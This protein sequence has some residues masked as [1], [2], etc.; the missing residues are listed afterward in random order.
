VIDSADGPAAAAAQLVENYDDTLFTPGLYLECSVRGCNGRAGD[1]GDGSPPA[2]S[3]T[4]PRWGSGANPP[5]AIGTM[6]YYAHKNWFLCI[7]CLYFIAKTCTEIER[8]GSDGYFRD[9]VPC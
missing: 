4:V 3:Q 2:E 5:E 9:D 6:K 7:I 8:T 1:L